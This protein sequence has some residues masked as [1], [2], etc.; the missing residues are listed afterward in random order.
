MTLEEIRK[1]I[2]AI[3]TQMKPIFL[4]RMECARYVAEEKE[5]TG[6]NVYVPEREREIIEKR[7]SV[8]DTDVREEY[9]TFLKHLM[10]VCRRY[11]YGFLDHMQ[12]DV[13][14]GALTIAGLCKEAE[15]KKVKI[16]YSCKTADHTLNLYLNMISLNQIVIEK[17][18]VETE[19]DIQIVTMELCGNVND[20]NM[21]QLL[22]Q[23]GKETEHFEIL[24]L[25]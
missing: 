12:A 4:Q 19:G 14:E 10:S 2:D 3:D 23:I 15:H 20:S 17:M 22:C 7:A 24:S 11:E 9:V 18:Q 8:V 5:K 1:Q 13:V 25:E 6:G 16:S 21:R